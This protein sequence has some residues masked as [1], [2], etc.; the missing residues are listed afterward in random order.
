MKGR[1]DR[2]DLLIKG[3]LTSTYRYRM[4]ICW[5]RWRSLNRYRKVNAFKTKRLNIWVSGK[6]A[7]YNMTQ[8]H[9]AADKS[10]RYEDFARRIIT[11]VWTLPSVLIL[12]PVLAFSSA[13]LGVRNT[14]TASGRNSGYRRTRSDTDENCQTA[15]RYVKFR[16]NGGA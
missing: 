14:T 12:T 1:L 5:R 3:T 11:S 2:P 13:K 6:A 15:D 7:F 4:T 16:R 10:L 8:W 9:A